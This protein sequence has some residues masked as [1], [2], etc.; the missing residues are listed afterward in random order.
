MWQPI[1][2]YCT[3][4]GGTTPND[5]LGKT[6]YDFY[7]KERAAEYRDDEQRV[8]RSGKPL[9]NKDEPHLDPSGTP[10]AVLTTKVPIKDGEGQVIG[11]V[12]ISRDITDRK[13]TEEELARERANLQAVF[14][15][16][17]VGMLVIDKDGAVK[18][19]NDTLSRWVK[20]TC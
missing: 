15:V 14:D 4:H 16:V 17:N 9:V 2:G 10:R 8:F 19:V 6:D 11:L 18:Q 13:R 12:G 3:G 20:R 7:P 5:L 1:S